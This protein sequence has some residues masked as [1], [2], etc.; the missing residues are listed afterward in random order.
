MFKRLLVGIFVALLTMPI[1]AYEVTLT[2]PLY[3]QQNSYYAGPACAKMI[4]EGYPPP[5]DPA[6]YTQDEIWAVIQTH[7]SGEPGWATDPE[8]M[9]GALIELNP[10]PPGT[11][12]SIKSYDVKE[13]LMF[14]ILFWM[15]NNSFPVTTLVNSG[16]HW[17][18]VVGYETD[19]E[20]IWG[21]DPELLQITIHDPWP[22]GQ[23]QVST[24]SGT[25]WYDTKWLNPVGNAGTWENKYVAV[26]EPPDIPGNVRFSNVDRRGTNAISAQDALQFSETWIDQLNLDAKN[27]AYQAITDEDTT[28]LAPLLVREEI[29]PGLAKDAQV[30]YYYIIPYKLK[31]D[32][33]TELSADSDSGYF[34][35]CVI[36]NAYSG[37]F[38]EIAAFGRALKYL[39]AD[40]AKDAAG[41][42]EANTELI[43][44][45]C[46]VTQVRSYAVWRIETKEETVYVDQ[47]GNVYKALTFQPYGR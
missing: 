34:S 42:K 35:M 43:F 22:I 5:Y 20:P 1:F 13:D 24:M 39:T 11:T 3:G 45:P 38:E 46:N 7:N 36:V 9:S 27:T 25:V 28:T 15:N 44:T 8:G 19:I 33:P 29:N 40:E 30:P 4:L 32:S 37:D 2:I 47:M 12:W 18:D 6:Y 17:V 41:V 21:S 23:G 31:T 10:P 16:N 14:Q 26:I